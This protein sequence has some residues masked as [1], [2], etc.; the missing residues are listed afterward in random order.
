[1]KD[2][3]DPIPV[4]MISIRDARETVFRRI[5][6]D[7]Q[8]LQERLNPSSS[9]YHGLSEQDAKCSHEEAWRN[10]DK[11]QRR[12]LKRLRDKISEGALVAQVR[13][14]KTG[15]ILKLDRDTWD[16]ISDFEIEITVVMGARQSVF[17]DPKEF[18]NVLL[19]IAPPTTGIDTAPVTDTPRVTDKG[20]RPTEYSW[21]TVKPLVLKELSAH[22]KPHK[23]NPRLPN[24][25]P[26]IDLVKTELGKFDQHPSDTAVKYSVD[27]WIAEF[28]KN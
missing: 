3:D 19:E 18:D 2:A 10:H 23:N 15:D 9:L 6:P 7:W 11:A 5:T 26:L 12:A 22:G 14:P 20:G 27:R 28:D 25:G 1:M 24:K 4:G 13:D 16:S 21:E 8:I 17:F